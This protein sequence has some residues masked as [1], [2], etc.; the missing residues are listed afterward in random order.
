MD[1]QVFADDEVLQGAQ[2]AFPPAE[3]AEFLRQLLDF[4]NRRH[5]EKFSSAGSAA[6]A[7]PLLGF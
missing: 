3:G 2:N 6:I 4:N 5:A 7:E 1:G